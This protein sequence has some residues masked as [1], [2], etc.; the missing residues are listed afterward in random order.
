MGGN[1]DRLTDLLIRYAGLFLRQGNRDLK[2]A[3]YYFN[4][5]DG[6]NE[7]NMR[8]WVLIQSG[9]S[10]I[11]LIEEGPQE[12]IDLLQDII[13]SCGCL[14]RRSTYEQLARDYYRT[15]NF[16]MGFKTYVKG[17]KRTRFKMETGYWDHMIDGLFM[18]RSFHSSEEL[19]QLRKILKTGALRY[20][21]TVKN[22]S[23]I[24]RLL[25]LANE[26]WIDEHIKLAEIEE[27]YNYSDENWLYIS[28]TVFLTPSIRTGL[29]YIKAQAERDNSGTNLFDWSGWVNG[30]LII[31]REIKS[32]KPSAPT[33]SGIFRIAN[34]T[35][36]KQLENY[37]NRIDQINFEMLGNAI[38]Q[39]VSKLRN[40]PFNIITEIFN[41]FKKT[42]IVFNLHYQRMSGRQKSSPDNPSYKV[43]I[44]L[45]KQ[46]NERQKM[47]VL[48][49]LKRNLNSEKNEDKKFKWENLINEVE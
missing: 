5:A 12:R 15:G 16:R 29:L 49:L 26:P 9:F 21:T 27:N 44:E 40:K 32:G 20:Q 42:N 13:D 19:K 35:F 25:S 41:S 11:A 43:M 37:T 2:E 30:W 38:C 47:S 23:T 24:A 46:G 3:E 18:N 17:V 10:G 34:E 22:A 31:D 48:S 6:I 1:A 28:N 39:R 45:C 4:W 14:P 8:V 7:G 36:I 33:D